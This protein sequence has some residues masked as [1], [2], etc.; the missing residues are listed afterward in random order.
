MRGMRNFLRLMASAAAL[1]TAC[2]SSAKFIPIHPLAASPG[3]RPPESVELF[4]A[5]PPARP[6]AELGIIEGGQDTHLSAHGTAE[7]LASMR[8]TAG[9]YGCDGLVL[10][11]AANRDGVDVDGNTRTVQGLRGTC[12]VWSARENARAGAHLP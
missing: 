1:V 10:T 4:T 2:G 5:G 12:I 7:I 8:K 6:Y 3:A 11:G 9:I